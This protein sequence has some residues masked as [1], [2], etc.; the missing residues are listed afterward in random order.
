MEVIKKENW[1]LFLFSVTM[2]SLVIEARIVM[3]QAVIWLLLTSVVSILPGQFPFFKFSEVFRR[4]IGRFWLYRAYSVVLLI[5]MSVL[6]SGLWSPANGDWLSKVTMRLPFLAMP[7]A[8]A[9]LP[10]VTKR[11][12]RIVFYGMLLL[13]S[14]VSAGVLLNYAFHFE[15]ITETLRHGKN[16]PVPMNHIR[17]SLLLGLGICSGILLWLEEFYI[18]FAWE[19]RIILGICIFLFITIHILSVRSGI[20]A[21][22]A[23]LALLGFRYYIVKKKEY[24]KGIALGASLMVI[25]ILAYLVLPSLQNKVMYSM[26]DMEQFRAGK[27]SDF[28]DSERFGSIMVGIDIGNRYPLLGCGYGNLDSEIRSTYQRVFPQDNECKLPHNQFVMTYAAAGLLGV[29]I[30][31]IAFFYPL[32]YRKNYRD[33]YFLALHCIVF[34]S[35][36]VEATIET[37]VGTLLYTFFLG[38][39]LNFNMAESD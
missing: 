24:L 14:I 38:L 29:F 28:S 18:R 8:F 3:S 6:L 30:L 21:L 10:A 36:L 37:Q 15:T 27:G 35:F 39:G 16:I 32:F 1:L 2:I 20:V 5:F 17:F 12:Y 23:T 11:N 9:W 4:H 34:C 7:L 33:W 31:L 22:Y 25:P 26:Y 19:R 13:L